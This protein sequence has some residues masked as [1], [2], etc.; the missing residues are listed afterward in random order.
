MLS[1]LNSLAFECFLNIPITINTNYGDPF[2]PSQWE[3]TLNKLKALK[4]CSYQGEIQIGSKWILSD[5]QIKELHS[6]NP[7][8]WFYCGISGINETQRFTLNERFDHY[9]RVAEFFER[10][11]V[12][13]RPIVPGRNDSIDILLPVIQTVGK[14][15][16]LLHH[17]GY[18]NPAIKDSKKY[19]YDELLPELK[20]ACRE[21]NV[22]D[23]PKCSCAVA[24]ITGRV[25]PTHSQN[26]PK[27]LSVLEAM[28]YDFELLD[29]RVYVSGYKG[30]DTV[31][32][33]DIAFVSHIVQSS[34][35]EKNWNKNSEVLQLSSKSENVLICTSSWF[36][37][38]R[39][40]NHC[41]VGCDYCFAKP[42]RWLNP[43][44]LGTNPLDLYREIFRE[45]R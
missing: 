41:D 5:A 4:R 15:R 31:H 22:R 16:G 23:Y 20:K 18:R 37:W 39:Q 17:G 27:N 25:C 43:Q 29:D 13:V 30:S 32:K 10:T 45:S 11:V 34:L 12:T 42:S 9:L 8:I 14:G 36:S 26:Q 40:L 3:D 24:D 33:G 38:S 35:V 21:N 19:G 6:V 28:G 7:K 44:N 1:T 2:Q